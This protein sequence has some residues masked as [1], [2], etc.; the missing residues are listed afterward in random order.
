MS[1]PPRP[2]RIASL[3]S[4]AASDIEREAILL[5]E[6]VNRRIQE[7]RESRTRAGGGEPPPASTQVGG[8][9]APGAEPPVQQKPDG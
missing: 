6:R 4:D 9:G 2:P 8:A 3:E 5:V 7:L 1:M